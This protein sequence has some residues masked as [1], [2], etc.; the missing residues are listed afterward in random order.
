MKITICSLQI[1]DD[2]LG[3]IVFCHL[4]IGMEVER[5]LAISRVNLYFMPSAGSTPGP[6]SKNAIAMKE[7]RDTHRFIKYC[8]LSF[9]G[10][11]KKMLK[12][13][14]LLKLSVYYV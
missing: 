12:S 14:Y 2:L 1:L 11:S 6:S 8:N 4:F 5:V 9:Y 7:K 10:V 13:P 3:V